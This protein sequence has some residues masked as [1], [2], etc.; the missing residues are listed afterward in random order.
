MIFQSFNFL[1]LFL[2]LVTFFYYI[3]PSNNWRNIILII[4]SFVFYAWGH[5]LWAALL[6]FSTVIDFTLAQKIYQLNLELEK[7]SDS[8][9][10]KTIN[11]K[12]KFFLI[13]SVAFNI[14][15]LAF[16]KYWDWLIDLVGDQTQLDLSSLQHGIPLP[17]AISFYTFESLSYIID[18]YRRQFKPTKNFIDYLTFVAFFPKLVAGPIKRANELLP[19][20]TK[21]RKRISAKA[22]ELALFMIFWG[23]FK[24]LVFADNLGHLVDRCKEN[25]FQP[26]VGFLMA[27]AFTFQLYCDFSAYADI[28]RGT[29]RLFS[30]KLR[31][32]FLTPF[33]S[34]SPT[35]F[36][37]RWNITLSNWI[38]DY[39]YIPLRG[40]GRN[41]LKNIFY[42]YFAML[43]F[44]VWHG[45]G[46]FFALYGIYSA[47]MIL[48]YRA[49]PINATF[50]RFGKVGKILSMLLMFLLITFGMGIFLTKNVQDFAAFTQSFFQ[51][52]DLIL[53]LIKTPKV[54][55]VLSYGL[56]LF[57]LPILITDILAYRRKREFVDL[58]LTFK[59]PL[60]VGI[61]LVMLYITLFFASRGSYDFIYFQF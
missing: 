6:I 52:N 44:G 31:R 16:F 21:F 36:F 42:L 4:A 55:F 37:Q 23:L 7:T 53:G 8:A 59:T 35:E 10:Q 43:L 28:A 60:K 20:L 30:I 17:P 1:L 24:K 32:N 45:A 47:T 34:T 49:I 58:Y 26:G 14:G 56:L 41:K 33:L 57:A 29:A 48:M 18:I 25:I 12:R 39:V 11:H 15:L 40:N 51:I 54:F 2:P 22:L 9:Q 13:C 50:A 27:I 5:L 19:Q 46:L 38:R 61:Y 3:T